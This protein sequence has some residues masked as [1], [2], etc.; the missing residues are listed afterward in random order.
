MADDF[1]ALFE[2]RIGVSFINRKLLRQAMTHRSYL[3][4]C[5]Y[6][7]LE[8]NERLEFLGDSVLEL[9]VTEALYHQFPDK[10]E[11]ELTNLRSALVNTGMLAET[12][13]HLGFNE[14]LLLSRGE[15]RDEGRA[16]QYIL[17][18]AFEA[19][20][21]ALYLDQGYR[22]VKQ[23][24]ARTL[25]PQLARI[26]AADSLKDPKGRFQEEAQEFTGITP[27]YRVLEESGPDHDHR[28]VVGAYFGE[29]LIATGRGPS[30]KEA[31]FDAA[32]AAL[33]K[34]GAL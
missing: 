27:T 19:V 14:Y 4:E 13:R 2:Q 17:A 7:G 1:F 12:A 31:E 33:E 32:A 6:A 28:F 26:L 23:F 16:R 15:T 20:I 30:R 25:L 10:P 8:H 18:C 29:V 11:G 34:K 9:V 22:T 5:R 21:G 3:N 24:I